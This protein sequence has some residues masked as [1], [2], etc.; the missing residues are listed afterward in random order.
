MY[1]KDL[2]APAHI[3]WWQIG[4]GHHCR[5]KFSRDQLQQ[6]EHKGEDRILS[7]SI[8]KVVLSIF[9]LRIFREL[10]FS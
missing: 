9:G 2:F 3:S 5:E 10:E 8:R 6:G 1:L 4:Q 7:C